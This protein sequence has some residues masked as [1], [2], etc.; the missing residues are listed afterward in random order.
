MQEI[1]LP[2]NSHVWLNGNSTL[3]APEVFSGNHRKVVLD[4]EAYFEIA[5]DETKPF[6]VRA[7]NTIIKV[8]GT[9]FNVETEKQSS[10]VSVIVNSGKVAF[11]RANGLQGK[12]ILTAGMKGQY[13]TSN[14]EI[15]I[16]TND[17]QNYLS[18]K[19]GLLT[20]YDTPLDE[21]CI[22]LSE[23]YRKDVKTNVSDT[24]LT[25]TGSF[26]N[27]TLEDI[28]KTIELTLD[29]KV[30]AYEGEILIHD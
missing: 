22:V 26:Q 25:L 4:G 5:R 20:F 30:T 14:R 21:V 1:V 24:N 12:S 17:D 16:S 28:L 7:G 3:R 18:W 8:L 6:K 19:T 9:S 29:I 23:Y 11:Y 13:R 15:K 2:D 27:E 10:T